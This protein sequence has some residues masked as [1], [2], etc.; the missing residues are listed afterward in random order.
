MLKFVS[1][2]ILMFS[3]MSMSAQNIDSAPI[4]ST[5]PS[6]QSGR[7]E[8]LPLFPSK[9]VDPRNID[10]WLPAN[11][12]PKKRYNVLYMH[13]GQMLYDAS[14]TWNKKAWH[15]DQAVTKL[16][17]NGQL[18][19]TIIVG[20]WNIAPLRHSEYFPEKALQWIAEPTRGRLIEK[21]LQG[22]ARA[23]NY[24]RFLVE[25]L[26]PAIDRQFSTLPDRDHTM[27]M[28]SSMGGLISIYAIS[29]YP[30]VFGG[31]ACLSTHWPGTFEANASV[32][33][34]FFNYLQLHLPDPA[35]H[36]IYMDRGT[37]TLDALYAV[38]Q[39]FVDLIVREKGYDDKHFISR[40]FEGAKHD[41]SDWSIRL[42][43]P[44]KFIA[45]GQLV[46]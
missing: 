30:E 20:V 27:I 33:L 46:N 22:K 10:V 21:G 1:F 36:R 16:V 4:A 37:A 13:D 29:E 42:E 19:D 6:V 41:E 24:L 9:Y 14:T 12:N 3:S 45:S 40:V 17:N 34:A 39:P 18:P 28:G 32:P 23:D 11:Y 2:L 35:H 38:P 8:R 25:E 43:L 26:K 7:I 31:A 15:V 44:L 5:M